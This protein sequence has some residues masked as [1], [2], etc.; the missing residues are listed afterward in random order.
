MAICYT[1]FVCVMN[2]IIRHTYIHTHTH[3]IWD[4]MISSTDFA[5]VACFESDLLRNVGWEKGPMRSLNPSTF[6]G[7][8]SSPS[9]E[10][11]LWHEG[12]DG[13]VPALAAAQRT[14]L[15]AQV[16]TQVLLYSSTLLLK[17][18][19]TQVLVGSSTQF[20]QLL[21]HSNISVLT[22]SPTRYIIS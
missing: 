20:A 4:E 1:Y 10:D 18:S 22:H 3:K 7:D 15:P 14:Q 21:K 5:C 8:H 16:N 19:Y 9:W 17:Y 12:G 2:K 11:P 13:E 6:P